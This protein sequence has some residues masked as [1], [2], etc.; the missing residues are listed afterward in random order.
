MRERPNQTRLKWLNQ[1]PS[2]KHCDECKNPIQDKYEK[3]SFEGSPNTYCRKCY[4][5]LVDNY[6]VKVEGRPVAMKAI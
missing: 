3:F 4:Y 2:K 5:A 1:F 6:P